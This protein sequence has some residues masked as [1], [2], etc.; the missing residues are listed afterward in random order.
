MSAPTTMKG[1]ILAEDN[2]MTLTSIPY[3]TPTLG[4]VTVRVLGTFVNPNLVHMLRASDN[5][6]SFPQ[7][8][9]FVPG[10]F[11]V[12]R[13]A[14]AGPDA[15]LLKEGQLVIVDPFVR[16]RDDPD[17]AQ[18]IWGM[19][20][21]VTPASKMLHKDIW[22]HGCLAE[23]CRAPLENTYA[24]DEKRLCGDVKDGGLGYSFT[25]LVYLAGHSIPYAGLR[26]I[27]FQAGE[28]VLVTPAT[29]Q[30]SGAAVTTALAMGG[31][32][33]AA[34]RSASGLERLR[35]LFPDVR[36]AQMTGDMEA[37]TAAIAEAAQGRAI[38]AVLETSPP[39]ATG[40]TSLTAC[41]LAVKPYGRIVLMGSRAD[42]SIPIPMSAL[43]YKNLT[44]KGS[45]MYERQQFLDLVKLA[46]AGQLKLNKESG[47]EIAGTYGL[48][49]WEKAAEEAVQKT[50]FGSV[51]A[52]V[53]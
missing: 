30:V 15:T 23:Y 43:L 49:E 20:D 34:S 13:V 51:V 47:F 36:T 44:I 31:R 24:L 2:S 32:V 52:M 14:A 48:E 6:H 53:P 33:I 18:I 5:A 17:H 12:G 22:R 4:S 25:E 50:A 37:D 38:D 10:S 8:R 41:M 42:T 11:A 9:P 16:G 19:F 39:A 46:E 29:G 35:K 3:P 21:G 28:T 26:S 1:L 27:N 40:S 45:F 7:P